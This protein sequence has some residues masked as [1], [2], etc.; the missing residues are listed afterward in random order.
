MKRI[1]KNLRFFVTVFTVALTCNFI[2]SIAPKKPWTVLIYIAG[3]NDLFQFVDVN[4]QQMMKV[5]T[6]ETVNILVY[7]CKHAPQEQKVAQKIVVNK[8]NITIVGQDYNVDSG[9]AQTVINACKW[10]Y[11]EFPS[12]HVAFI[13]WDHGSGPL[14]RLPR[15]VCYDFTTGHYLTD[16]DLKDAFQTVTQQFLGNRKIDIIGWDACLMAAAE[17]DATLEPYADYVVASQQT[18]P[19]PGWNYTRAFAPFLY[20]ITSPNYLARAWV[21]AYKQNYSLV[22]ADYT[23]SAVQLSGFNEF[24]NSIDIIAAHLI[25]LLQYQ[26]NRSVSLAIAQSVKS[27][28]CVSY[29]D[30][31][32]IDLDNFY[33]NLIPLLSNIT[34]SNA[35]EAQGA[36]ASLSTALAQG[37]ALI[38]KSVI[39]NVAGRDDAGSAG[40]SIYFPRSKKIHA[41]YYFLD[42]TLH[43]PLWLEFLKVYFAK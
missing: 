38:K 18:I 40:I 30:G 21:A 37:R 42:W 31:T 23:L 28:N 1:M 5:G 12:D 39:A 16:I 15:G 43:H 41:S 14:N 20:K 13:G 27:T 19:G 17:L 3:D 8:N 25:K 26:T 29:D 4:L 24:A 10:A 35:F 2:E 36:V 7:L 33:A 32:Y 9:V 34:V 11:T 6:N 22:T